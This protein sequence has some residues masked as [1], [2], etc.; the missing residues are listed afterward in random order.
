MAFP[1]KLSVSPCSPLFIL[2]NVADLQA[3]CSIANYLTCFP[4][5]EFLA[6]ATPTQTRLTRAWKF[7]WVDRATPAVDRFASRCRGIQLFPL[8]FNVAALRIF[9]YAIP[10]QNL[11]DLIG[12]RGCHRCSISPSSYRRPTSATSIL[13]QVSFS[14]RPF[15]FFVSS[16]ERMIT[17]VQPIILAFVASVCLCGKW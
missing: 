5:A 2:S 10:L 6:P 11:H 12:A 1:E 13:Q 7:T 3:S 4:A 16:Y 9:Q 17:V 14:P 8:F 15:K